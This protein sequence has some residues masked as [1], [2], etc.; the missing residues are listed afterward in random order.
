MDWVTQYWMTEGCD[1]WE[2][3]ISDDFYFNR[4]GYVYSLN[5]VADFAELIGENGAQYRAIGDEIREAT[6]SH[7]R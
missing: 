4:L 5:V 2:E 6:K 7:W 1:L 3:F